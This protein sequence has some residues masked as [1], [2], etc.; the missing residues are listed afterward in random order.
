ML[1]SRRIRRGQSNGSARALCDESSNDGFLRGGKRISI[2]FD[3]R[4]IYKE[5]CR[6]TSVGI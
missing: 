2:L 4:L 3:E 1:G 5:D 6:V